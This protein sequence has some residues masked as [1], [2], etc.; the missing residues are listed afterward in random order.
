MKT[1]SLTYE[2]SWRCTHCK[3]DPNEPDEMKAGWREQLGAYGVERG[4]G[5]S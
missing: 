3:A 2:T 1:H 5:A 4:R